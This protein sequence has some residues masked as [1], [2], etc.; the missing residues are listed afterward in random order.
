MVQDSE[1]EREGSLPGEF[2]GCRADTHTELSNP[3][4]KEIE[5]EF[6][7]VRWLES[8]GQSGWG[9]LQQLL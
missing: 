8:E 9:A 1:P 5:V 7:E 3:Q 2:P 6:R 4:A